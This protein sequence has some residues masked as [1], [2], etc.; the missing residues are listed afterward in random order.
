MDIYEVCRL[1]LYLNF[2]LS[3]S[4][5]SNSIDRNVN[6]E[7]VVIVFFPVFLVKENELND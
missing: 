5:V 2:D 6:S 7:Y 4:I 1:L 3:N